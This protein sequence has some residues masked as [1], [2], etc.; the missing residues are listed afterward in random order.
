MVAVGVGNDFVGLSFGFLDAQNIR[1]L[2]FKE[3]VEKVF[4][5]D[6]PNAVYVPGVEFHE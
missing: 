3:G 5:D 6:G 1:L 4:A 2:G